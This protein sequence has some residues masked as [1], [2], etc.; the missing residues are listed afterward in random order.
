LL[1]SRTQKG[2]VRGPWGFLGKPPWF[3]DHARAHQLWPRLVRFEAK[4]SVLKLPGIF[5]AFLRG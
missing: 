3:P 4:H 5:S 2:V 1:Y